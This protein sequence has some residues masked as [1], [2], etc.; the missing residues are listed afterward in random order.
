MRGLRMSYL[1][2]FATELAFKDCDT[3]NCETNCNT[4]QLLCVIRNIRVL[5]ELRKIELSVYLEICVAKLINYF[6]KMY[7]VKSAQ[8]SRYTYIIEAINV[9][10]SG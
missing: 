9:Y 2:T 10:Y 6:Y 3:Y 4:I 1:I 5:R 7:G 8:Y